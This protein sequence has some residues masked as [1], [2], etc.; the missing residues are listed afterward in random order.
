MEQKGGGPKHAMP[1]WNSIGA[2]VGAAILLLTLVTGGLVWGVVAT[3]AED[4]FVEQNK[5]QART[6]S[7]IIARDLAEHML[8]GGGPAIWADIGG[9]ARQFVEMGGPTRVLALNSVG[10]IKASSDGLDVGGRIEV[11][12]N[13]ECPGCDWSAPFPASARLA[14]PTGAPRLRVVS[15][16]PTSQPCLGCHKTLDVARGFILVDFDLSPLQKAANTRN[17]VIL[18]LGAGTTLLLVLLLAF[19]IRRMVTRPLASLEQSMDRLADGNLSERATLT[20]NNEIAILA[21]HFNHMAQRMEAAR[22]EAT[23]LYELVV[24]ASKK[25]EMT[26]FAKNVCQVIHNN[27]HPRN[28]AFLLEGAAGGW[29]CARKMDVQDAALTTG[30]ETLDNA[31]EADSPTMAL[32]ANPASVQLATEAHRTL[33]LQKTLGPV[34]ESFALP[35]VSDGRLIGMLFCVDVPSRIALGDDLIANL[36]VHLMLAANNSRHYTGATTDGMT[37]LS[38]KQ[39]G[40]VRLEEALFAAKRY[41]NGL[42]LAMCDIDH[43]KRVND[44]YGHL[45]GDSVLREVARRIKNCVRK[46]DTAVRYGGEEFMLIIPQVNVDSLALLGEKIRHA[47]N[48]TPISL[49]AKLDPIYVTISIGIAADNARTEDGHALIARA[50][51]ALYRAK[52]AGRNR[53]EVDY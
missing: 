32:L 10:V 21:G 44:T 22:T 24:E 17:K 19:L 6:I 4:E 28:S 9:E 31:F 30:D 39:Y 49:G 50:D 48:V 1:L 38:N 26:D 52:N 37:Q 29:I 18:G 40:L 47:V 33:K 41:K 45:A 16:I 46:S 11:R 51:A 7:T 34:G 20:V 15:S 8:A 27:L 3:M 36:G 53:V 23:L 42:I 35:V 43:F 13:P 25:L 12:A 5:Q 2:R 14:T